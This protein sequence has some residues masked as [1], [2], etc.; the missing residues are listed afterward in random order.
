[1]EIVTRRYRVG[2]L[3]FRVQA[4][5]YPEQPNMTDF[6]VEDGGP[7]GPCLRITP[8]E[9]SE[10]TALPCVFKKQL[11]ACYRRGDERVRV[12]YREDH[13]EGLLLRAE[14]R[15]N[16]DCDVVLAQDALSGLGGNLVLK[17]MELPRRLLQRGGVFLHASMIETEGGAILFTAQKQIGKSTQAEL[18]RVHR[19]AR[20]VNGDRA[21][22]QR[23]NGVWHAFGSPYCGTSSYCERAELPLAAVVQLSQAKENRVSRLTL[24]AAISAFLEGCAYDPTAPAQ[25]AAVMDLA[26]AIYRD[27]PFYHLACLPDESAVACL[28]S[29]LKQ[30]RIL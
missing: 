23:K 30:N 20:I 16:G 12:F 2:D 3:C 1:M 17:L 26:A 10:E 29:A 8:G 9:P 6:R 4:P 13:R 21:L 22:V 27:V 7:D 18:W 5:P 15:P 25:T 24:K 19:G 28:E 11:E 14:D